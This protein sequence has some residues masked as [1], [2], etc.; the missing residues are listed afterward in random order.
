MKPNSTLLIRGVDP[1]RTIA[2]YLAIWHVSN[3]SEELF[4]AKTTRSLTFAV[5]QAVLGILLQ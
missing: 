5:V 3:I 1:S 2:V 4:Q